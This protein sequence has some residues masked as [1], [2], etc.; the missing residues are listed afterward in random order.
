M[1]KNITDVKTDEADIVVKALKSVSVKL[2]QLFQMVFMVRAK[3]IIE[4]FINMMR[5]QKQPVLQT[6]LHTI[7]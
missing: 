2:F 5:H 3:I 6:V 1:V 4:I 7:L